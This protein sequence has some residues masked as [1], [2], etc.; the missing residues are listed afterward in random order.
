MEKD[1]SRGVKPMPSSTGKS[2]SDLEMQ[3]LKTRGRVAV[4]CLGLLALAILL[5]LSAL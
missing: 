1:D 3:A 5:G 4:V 2:L